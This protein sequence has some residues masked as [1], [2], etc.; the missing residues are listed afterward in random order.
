LINLGKYGPFNT[1]NTINATL[2]FQL[3]KGTDPYTTITELWRNP[4]DNS[5]VASNADDRKSGNN[6]W[7]FRITGVKNP[8]T[9]EYKKFL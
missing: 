2:V 9:T 1:N 3:K 4:Y 6:T 8:I 5:I 7:N